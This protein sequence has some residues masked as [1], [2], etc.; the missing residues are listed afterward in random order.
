MIEIRVGD[1]FGNYLLLKIPDLG[2][3]INVSSK[4]KFN[5][6]IIWISHEIFCN[7]TKERRSFFKNNKCSTSTN[8]YIKNSF[9]NIEPQFDK[10]LTEK[11]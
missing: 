9:S 10:I 11:H 1:I 4:G 6:I 3:F 2:K 7:T 5:L 8:R